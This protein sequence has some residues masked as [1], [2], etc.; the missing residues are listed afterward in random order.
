MKTQEKTDLPAGG[1]PG[2]LSPLAVSEQEQTTQTHAV[3]WV[4]SETGTL[5]KA[6]ELQSRKT[7]RFTSLPCAVS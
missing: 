4:F 7:A 3:Q 2:L 6:A 1:T 5:S